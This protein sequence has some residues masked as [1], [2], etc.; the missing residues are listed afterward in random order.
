[1]Y[2][3]GALD[4]TMAVPGAAD[5]SNNSPLILGTSVCQCCDG[6]TPYSGAAKELQL[7]SHALSAAEVFAICN[8][9]KS[10]Q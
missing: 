9:G 1:V 4:N 10:R 8:A 7:F 2:V 6:T 5:V 3:D